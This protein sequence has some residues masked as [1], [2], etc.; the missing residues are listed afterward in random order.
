MTVRATYAYGHD[1][2]GPKHQHLTEAYAV[3]G[4]LPGHAFRDKRRI[5][6]ST[7]D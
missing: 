5:L 7:W 1:E 4:C 2:A 6:A 3:H